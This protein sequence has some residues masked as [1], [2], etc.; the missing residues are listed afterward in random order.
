[1]LLDEWAECGISKAHL[2]A[3][4]CIEPPAG[5]ARWSSGYWPAKLSSWTMATL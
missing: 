1:M 5:F 3:L 2:I 4:G